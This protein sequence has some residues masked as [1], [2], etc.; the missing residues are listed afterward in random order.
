MIGSRAWRWL[1]LVSMVAGVAGAAAAAGCGGGD[2]ALPDTGFDASDEGTTQPPADGAAT[3]DGNTL[4]PGVVEVDDDA[5]ASL[6]NPVQPDGGAMDERACFEAPHPGCPNYPPGAANDAGLIITVDTDGGT[7]PPLQAPPDCNDPLADECAPTDPADV[8][9]DDL[10]DGDPAC[11]GN[12]GP[13]LGCDTDSPPVECSSQ[14]PAVCGKRI[15]VDFMAY[16]GFD[17]N[18][19]TNGC[20]LPAAPN[21]DHSYRDCS[22]PA[23]IKR[24]DG[25]SWFYNYV[26]PEHEDVT[27]ESN[28][29]ASCASGAP[30]GYEF[31][32]RDATKWRWV[33]NDN[34]GAYF[35]RIFSDEGHMDNY[36]NSYKKRRANTIGR[37][38]LFMTVN[39]GVPYAR[40]STRKIQ[41]EVYRLCK[42]VPNYA[43]FSIYANFNYNLS[44]DPRMK[45]I[46]AALNACTRPNK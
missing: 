9:C 24:T 17:P 26:T 35:A 16:G 40:Y 7:P 11:P 6:G 25:T 33:V 5:G 46:I 38:H 44:A 34:A 30:G 23:I 45:R 36:Y 42:R 8:I 3:Q 31:F 15:F 37:D 4:P 27:V 2:D 22:Y 21:L 28:T 12:S 19:H 14:R 13:A 32:G 39:V 41:R 10:E 1:G 29:V 18:I 43:H 20:W